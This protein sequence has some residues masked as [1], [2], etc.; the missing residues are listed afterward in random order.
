MVDPWVAEVA[1][2]GEG[3]EAGL[4]SVGVA[5][6]L[7]AA[8]AFQVVEAFLQVVHGPFQEVVPLVVELP[9]PHHGQDLPTQVGLPSYEAE[10]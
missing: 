8:A 5:S 1:I 4:A 10:A 7:E 6:C 9:F 2:L 3:L